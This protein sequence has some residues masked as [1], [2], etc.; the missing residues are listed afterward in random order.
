MLRFGQFYHNW[1]NWINNIKKSKEWHLRFFSAPLT[2]HHSFPRSGRQESS[3]A[4]I[5]L[6]AVSNRLHG[7]KRPTRLFKCDKQEVLPN[8]PPSFFFS[9]KGSPLSKQLSMGSFTDGRVK[10]ISHRY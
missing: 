5:Q 10:N 9:L 6:Q 7:E 2:V 4:P 8:R 1:T 3:L